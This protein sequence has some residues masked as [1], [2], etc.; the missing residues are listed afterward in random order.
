[1][2]RI[3]LIF[4]TLA[5][6]LLLLLQLGKYVLFFPDL[7]SEF[8]LVLWAL[9]LLGVGVLLAR[10]LGRPSGDSSSAAAPESLSPEVV[11]NR[12]DRLDITPR[13]YEV[14]E[15]LAEGLSNRGIAEALF[16]SETTVKSHV[17]S[18][19]AKLQARRRTEAVAKARD[20]GILL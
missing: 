20:Y 19:L 1:M 7:Q 10:F 9:A 15:R 6:T 16:I 3:V 18:L 4:G 11:Q 8:L 5:L 14:L 12:L 13:E 17:S 2:K